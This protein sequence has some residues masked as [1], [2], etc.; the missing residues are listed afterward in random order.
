MAAKWTETYVI[1]CSIMGP[2]L[3]DNTFS[4]LI[5]SEN[6][7]IS[8]V[9]YTESHICY[10]TCCYS[11]AETRV[12]LL[13]IHLTELIIVVSTKRYF[14]STAII[15]LYIFPKN[16]K[17]RLIVRNRERSFDHLPSANLCK[18]VT[19]HGMCVIFRTTNKIQLKIT[20]KFYA[21]HDHSDFRRI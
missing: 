21:L 5:E 4:F 18:H 16:N 10:N 20:I 13:S 2:W 7:C 6:K 17:P 8:L 19:S 9:K 1:K 11:L 12:S 3:C 15:Y 14:V